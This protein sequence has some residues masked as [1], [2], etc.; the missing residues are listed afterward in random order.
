MYTKYL[1]ALT[2]AGAMSSLCENI[3]R[4]NKREWQL[5]ILRVKKRDRESSSRNEERN[6]QQLGISRV[7]KRDRVAEFRETTN[8]IFRDITCTCLATIDK[9]KV[10]DKTKT[11]L[12]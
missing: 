9:R 11:M 5:G 7:D 4:N 2:T 1:H 8:V 10:Y 3:T 6:L 12:E